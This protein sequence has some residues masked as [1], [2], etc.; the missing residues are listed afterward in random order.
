MYPEWEVKGGG[1]MKERRRRK[2]GV[3]I[4]RGRE[5]YWP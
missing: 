3:L 5:V 2:L 4:K 1:G